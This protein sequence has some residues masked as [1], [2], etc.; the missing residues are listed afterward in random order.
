MNFKNTNNLRTILL[1][2]ITSIKDLGYICCPARTL[3]SRIKFFKLGKSYKKQH[4][5]ILAS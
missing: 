3:S 4:K 1:Y 5:K 2:D